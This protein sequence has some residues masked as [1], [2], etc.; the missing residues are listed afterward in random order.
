M[1]YRGKML[2]YRK[3]YG[4]AKT[5]MLRLMLGSLSLVKMLPWCTALAIPSWRHRAS[6]ELRSNLDVLRLCLTLT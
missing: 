3:N 2:F 4:L 6:M 5:A 1:V